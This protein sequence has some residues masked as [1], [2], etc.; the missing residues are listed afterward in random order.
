MKKLT[1]VLSTAICA[2]LLQ[3]CGG[4]TK[5]DS[6]ATADSVNA[7]KDT[8]ATA[9]IGVEKGDAAFAT[10]AA[11]GGMVEVVLAKMVQAK[12]SDAQ[13]KAFADK[14]VADH[15]KANDELKDIAKSK[16]ITLPPVPGADEQKIIDK[17]SKKTGKD[18][19][20]AY[21]DDMVDD[22]KNDVKKFTDATKNVKDADLNAF[23]TKTLPVLQMHLD[24][25]TKIH[26][27]MK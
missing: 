10:E 13:V 7:T 6:K 22:H 16:S 26:D 24:M 9:S 18:L 12:G 21:V 11:S 4:N 1:L 14:M 17:L 15:T 23:A 19:D 5:N 25:I 8:S 20:K 27:S 3:A 2:C